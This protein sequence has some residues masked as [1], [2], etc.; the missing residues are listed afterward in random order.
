MGLSY[1]KF[2]SFIFKFLGRVLLYCFGIKVK[3]VKHDIQDF[4]PGY[5]SS[6]EGVLPGV[7]V[8]N[9]SSFLDVFALYM[10]DISFLSKEGV[11]KVPVFGDLAI[12][13]MC[14][15][16]NR[17]DAKDKEKVLQLL[18]ERAEN[19]SQGKISPLCVFPEGTVTNGRSLMKF[20][21]GAFVSDKPIKIMALK[22]GDDSNYSTSMVNI[23]VIACI[24]M[25]ICQPSLTLEIHEV[26]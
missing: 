26:E 5:K 3:Y 16:V 15:F 25:T 23:N 17:D 2:H 20:K 8:S 22:W 7:V 24:I 6:Q 1:I 10:Q 14:T 19:A 9:H 13:R 12:T 21:K 11:V 4:I 18:K